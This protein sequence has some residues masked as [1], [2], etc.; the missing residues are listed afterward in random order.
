M[1]LE[2]KKELLK[3]KLFL[4]AHNYDAYTY[5]LIKQEILSEYIDKIN[6]NSF[7]IKTSIRENEIEMK[8]FIKLIDYFLRFL[9]DFFFNKYIT[10]HTVE[11]I[12]TSNKGLMDMFFFSRAKITSYAIDVDELNS[13]IRK[14]LVTNF[15][16][17]AKYISII[18]TLLAENKL[19]LK[20]IEEYTDKEVKKI[21][22]LLSN[23]ILC[24]KIH[25]K[26]SYS[27]LFINIDNYVT[28]HM[29]HL[30]NIN[31]KKYNDSQ[32]RTKFEEKNISD[33]IKRYENLIS[34]YHKKKDYINFFK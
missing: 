9:R 6:D 20:R 11:N 30:K 12:I 19:K 14:M 7:Y 13:I 32:Y 25:G 18:E 1:T 17:N 3:Y 22:D 4:D 27:Y 24:E 26:A 34:Y 29:S 16:F 15:I 23:I 5:Y 33:H 21:V 28:D 10:I 2:L 8:Q 31:S